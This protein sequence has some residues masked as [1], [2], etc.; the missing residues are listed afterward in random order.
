MS[1]L[2]LRLNDPI[3]SALESMM[4]LR[5]ALRVDILFGAL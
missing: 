3:E 5:D 1:L 4:E 2:L